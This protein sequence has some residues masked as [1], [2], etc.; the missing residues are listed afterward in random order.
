MKTSLSLA[1]FKYMPLFAKHQTFETDFPIKKSTFP[2][3]GNVLLTINKFQDIV[4]VP[5]DEP[6]Y[7]TYH[8][9]LFS[10]Q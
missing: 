9:Q 8:T 3:I 1:R 7:G 5:T 10:L 4:R 2:S 6:L